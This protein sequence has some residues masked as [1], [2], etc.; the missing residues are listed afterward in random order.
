MNKQKF[1][2]IKN[3]WETKEY[4]GEDEYNMVDDIAFLIAAYENQGELLQLS[5]VNVDRLNTE[6]TSVLVCNKTQN[7]YIHRLKKEL[8]QA[9]VELAEMRVERDKFRAF[10]KAAW[11]DIADLRKQL[12]ASHAVNDVYRNMVKVSELTIEL[13]ET[14]GEE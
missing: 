2:D 3:R 8:K 6:N 5:L 4:M 13:L 7:D 10:E 1:L 12:D 14:D 9:Q 11:D